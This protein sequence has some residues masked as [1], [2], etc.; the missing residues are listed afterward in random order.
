MKGWLVDTRWSI[1]KEY[2]SLICEKIREE[3]KEVGLILLYY[4]GMFNGL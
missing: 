2:S 3:K 4:V 1:V